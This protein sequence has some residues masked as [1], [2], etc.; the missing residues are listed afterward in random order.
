MVVIKKE[1]DQTNICYSKYTKDQGA[2]ERLCKSLTNTEVDSHSQPVVL[3]GGVGKGTEG[4]GGFCSLI[5]EATVSLTR[6]PRACIDWTN[7]KR[8]HMEGPMAL[9]T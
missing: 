7:N 9:T 8:I 3:N 1:L 5:G 6:L 4:A 2:A